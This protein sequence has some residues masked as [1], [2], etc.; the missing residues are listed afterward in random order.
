MS[1][2]TNSIARVATNIITG[3]LGA[4]KTSVILHLLTVKPPQERWAILVNEFGEIGIDGSLLSDESSA[5][6]GVYIREVPGGCM[7]CT[8]GMPMRVALAQLL[9]QARP[10]RL[11][12]EPTGL[13]HP[14]EVLETLAEESFNSV[15]EIQNTLTLVDA[16][17]LSKSRYADHDTYQKQIG[18]ADVIIANKRDLYKERDIA[19]L[20]AYL[21]RHSLQDLNVVFSEQGVI[22][23]ALLDKAKPGNSLNRDDVV[24]PEMEDKFIE[25]E[26]AIPDCGFVKAVNQGEGYFSIGWRFSPSLI[27]DQSALFGFL[28]GVE[29][30]RVKATII[31]N[32]GCFAYNLTQ[33]TLSEIPMNLIDESRIEIIS[34]QLNVDWEADLFACLASNDFSDQIDIN[35]KKPNTVQYR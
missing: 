14:R 21:E 27:F 32:N 20:T 33:D 18:I 34:R 16:R 19:A 22:D 10:D 5:E 6:E 23:C 15:L 12:I 1:K 2:S 17:Q 31:T 29:A 3:F 24:L 8:A 13:G 9:R 26:M 35:L 25:L 28:S 7:C 11:L 4:G 30:E